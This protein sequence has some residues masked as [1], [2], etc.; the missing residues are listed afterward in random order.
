MRTQ[1]DDSRS[2]PTTDAGGDLKG[3]LTEWCTAVATFSHA[4]YLLDETIAYVDEIKDISLDF[5]DLYD[6]LIDPLIEAR[7]ALDGASD[8]ARA[9]A[10][11]C[12]DIAETPEP[13]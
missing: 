13:E 12:G 2:D 5:A 3:C 11:G 1:N 4:V 6:T 10:R 9:L 8:G 7:Y